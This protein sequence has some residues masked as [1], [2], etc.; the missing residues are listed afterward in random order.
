MR[1]EFIR[2]YRETYTEADMQ[3]LIRFYQTDFGKRLMASMPVIMAKS[4]EV[5][6]QRVQ[7]ALPELIAEVQARMS[8]Q[9]GAP[10]PE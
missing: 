6:S 8:S 10:A 7:A 1:P 4:N 2:I 9:V 5:S 3:E